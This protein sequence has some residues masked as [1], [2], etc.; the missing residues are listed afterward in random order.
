MTIQLAYAEIQ[1][2][3]TSNG[4]VNKWMANPTV[5]DDRLYLSIL[6]IK[7]TSINKLDYKID[8]YIDNFIDAFGLD[9]YFNATKVGV[10]IF[11]NNNYNKSLNM[12][13]KDEIL[14]SI[15]KA[16][17]VETTTA[18]AIFE[19]GISMDIIRTSKDE[20][21]SFDVE[22]LIT[23]INGSTNKI[24]EEIENNNNN[25]NTK[26]YF[27]LIDLVGSEE[28]ML[29]WLKYILFDIENEDDI[30]P[31]DYKIV[32]PI[33]KENFY[34]PQNH[35]TPLL[36]IYHAKQCEAKNK[37][38]LKYLDFLNSE[39]IGFGVISL[40][41]ERYG[42]CRSHYP[43]S[44]LVLIN[45]GHPKVLT[46]RNYKHVL[47][48]PIGYQSHQNDTSVLVMKRPSQKQ[49]LYSFA[50]NIQKFHRH[51][52]LKEMLK[53]NTTKY[54]IKIY[55]TYAWN[56]L[57][58][59]KEIDYL[60][61]LRDSIFCPT[62][63]GNIY[64]N[65]NNSYQF[66]G[67]KGL[68]PAFTFNMRFYEAMEAGCIPIVEDLTSIVPNF[69]HYWNKLGLGRYN[70]N[71]SG[72]LD[73]VPFLVASNDWGN[74]IEIMEPFLL[75]AT[76]LEKLQLEML[77]WWKQIKTNV[78][79]NIRKHILKYLWKPSPMEDGRYGFKCR[80]LKDAIV[81]TYA[82]CLDC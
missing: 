5:V 23:Y 25:N 46:R 49:Y 18:R 47:E 55:M 39:R 24:D 12:M 48:F 28:S 81:K 64:P 29:D 27:E 75:N 1:P 7:N 73:E 4:N 38:L 17:T 26:K 21:W 54:N 77:N 32:Q 13:L 71:I 63:L 2:S 37:P 80:Y 50:G 20:A 16:S 70:V 65:P 53:I 19:S 82:C 9:N 31:Y 58:S 3:K 61:M 43:S 22:N 30:L 66:D 78:K 51:L 67:A 41:D 42:G 76:K 14:N 74:V 10:N 56:D 36:I 72:K 6:P 59:M 52:M 40:H 45:T 35:K 62:P 34:K 69:K 79:R 33:I 60:T 68:L 15:K 8:D 57:T 11:K 44:R